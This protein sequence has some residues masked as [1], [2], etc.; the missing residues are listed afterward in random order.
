MIRPPGVIPR[1]VELV[2]Y[3]ETQHADALH[4]LIS[5]KSENLQISALDS[6]LGWRD[7]ATRMLDFARIFHLGGPLG[8]VYRGSTPGVLLSTRP[9][10]LYST[11]LYSAQKLLDYEQIIVVNY[12]N[13][14]K[15]TCKHILSIAFPR[16]FRHTFHISSFL[17]FRSP[18][19]QK[20]IPELSQLPMTSAMTLVSCGA[21]GSLARTDR[22]FMPHTFR[23][24]L[25]GWRLTARV[26]VCFG[27]RPC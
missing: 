19:T 17:F 25:T 11:L 22:R 5:P 8:R 7:Q 10:A 20:R 2:C 15:S 6:R 18:F 21:L 27:R 12:P 3:Q 14:K 4:R 16:S 1:H 26:V 23:S 13:A 24:R 9:L